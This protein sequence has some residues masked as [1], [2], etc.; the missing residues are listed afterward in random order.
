M[1]NFAAQIKEWQTFYATMAAACATLV[2]LLFVAVS[3]NADYLLQKSN[4]GSL[5][6]ART[7]FR[8]F[9]PVL[10]MALL[11][12][13]PNLP[14]FGLGS[15]LMVLGVAGLVSVVRQIVASRRSDSA[16]AASAN[17]R[18][19]VLS[20][21]GTIGVIALAVAMMLE[22]TKVLYW[23]VVVWAALLS[24]A[25]STAWALLTQARTNEVKRGR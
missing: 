7:A 14:P 8:D 4:S 5:R 16:A 21:A 25:S 2:G 19:Y 22:Y 23:L 15:G 1:D 9:L 12:L 10:L 11:F 3:L 17:V 24:S 18:S 20:L 6:V 13:I